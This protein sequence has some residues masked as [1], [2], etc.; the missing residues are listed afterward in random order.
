MNECTCDD[1]LL[2]AVGI[3]ALCPICQAEYDAYLAAEYQARERA[4]LLSPMP[5]W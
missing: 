3:E 4:A 5:L 1:K 2:R